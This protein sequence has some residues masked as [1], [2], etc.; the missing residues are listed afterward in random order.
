M[1]RKHLKFGLNSVFR[2]IQ[3]LKVTSCLVAGDVE[4]NLLVTHLVTAA[5]TRGIPVLIVP[6]L[7]QIT[8]RELGFS[9]TALG[10]SVCI[11]LIRC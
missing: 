9:C 8:F 5:S 11:L 2:A 4:P 3:L 6:K 7:K 10:I 1:F